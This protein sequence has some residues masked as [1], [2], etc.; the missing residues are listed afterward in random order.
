MY[1][2]KPKF[3]IM[4]RA[5]NKLSICK[6]EIKLYKYTKNYLSSIQLHKNQENES[7]HLL[8]N[9]ISSLKRS[10]NA[11]WF[12]V[13]YK[14]QREQESRWIPFRLKQAL[15]ATDSPNIGNKFR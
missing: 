6:L 13:K 8:T 3:F 7:K 15:N 10:Q 11:Y 4:R 1:Q 9:H 14:S 12:E 2:I 5:F